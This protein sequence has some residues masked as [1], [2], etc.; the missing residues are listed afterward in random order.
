[1]GPVD[2]PSEAM[3]SPFGSMT[4]WRAGI[5][6][7]QQPMMTVP[8]AA[9]HMSELQHQQHNTLL[10]DGAQI[11]LD[12]SVSTAI[13]SNGPVPTLTDHGRDQ[14]REQLEYYFSPSNLT[15]DRFLLSHMDD[16]RYV[17]ISVIA[18]F[19]RVKAVTENMS[20]IVAALRRSSVVIVDPTGSKV[21]PSPPKPRTT[22]IIRD[23][24]HDVE[25]KEILAVFEDG[26]C[27]AKGITREVAN[28]WF[29]EFNKEEDALA[30]HTF[31]RGK[32][33]RG[34]PL[35]ARLK[36]NTSFVGGL[37]SDSSVSSH[38]AVANASSPLLQTDQSVMSNIAPHS[39]SYGRQPYRRFPL[40]FDE[41][42]G[43]SSNISNTAEFAMNIT[44]QRYFVGMEAPPLL[45]QEDTFA[46][47]GYTYIPTKMDLNQCPLEQ[48][49]IPPEQY[50][51][52]QEITSRWVG[53]TGCTPKQIASQRR[54]SGISHS[55]TYSLTDRRESESRA[56][57]TQKSR[58]GY[59][60]KR[61][62]TDT[63]GIRNSSNSMSINPSRIAEW[64][65]PKNNVLQSGDLRKI[66]GNML[67]MPSE[68]I[69]CHSRQGN[70][71]SASSSAPS[72]E[73][74]DRASADWDFT[75]SQRP[76]LLPA[77]QPAP[78]KKKKNKKK[79]ATKSENR[80]HEA[81]V[82]ET[83]TD[84]VLKTTLDDFHKTKS[85]EKYKLGQSSS[86]DKNG[87]SHK[88]D[89]TKSTSSRSSKQQS[90]ENIVVDVKTNDDGEE[91]SAFERSTNDTKTSTDNGAPGSSTVPSV[92]ILRKK[93][94]KNAREDDRNQDT[95]MLNERSFKNVYVHNDMDMH[96]TKNESSRSADAKSME[97]SF[98]VSTSASSTDEASLTTTET[99]PRYEP[100]STSCS[101]STF[102]PG[103]P[104][105]EIEN[106][107]KSDTE[108]DQ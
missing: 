59:H 51:Q 52:S 71:A 84:Q 94:E 79:K 102:A 77:A 80:A 2:I 31:I 35:A 23:L 24:P 89:C 105:P 106:S 85:T 37:S 43:S 73:V 30:M 36:S 57:N 58:H 100:N 107:V 8:L 97:L 18:E 11:Y 3:I 96:D 108:E 74:Q 70:F 83:L 21:K 69:R 14:L 46:M 7:F 60:G 19:K 99:M 98:T 32:K 87:S 20:E 38:S 17:P 28:T 62:N 72:F 39:P 91:A 40:D 90:A 41:H 49:S 92:N 22:L 86:R 63:S 47:E 13:E 50:A 93:L 16:E 33:L 9:P 61:G 76:Q 34:V 12:H 6:Y 27:P 56:L 67:P 4:P 15:V 1:M 53:H 103:P 26:G 65:I 64:Y 55:S 10:S 101:S 68:H 5:H 42:L 66:E 44:P 78:T 29:V 81:T 104:S 45:T 82:V 75:L 25:A 48:R 88:N 95:Q 54:D